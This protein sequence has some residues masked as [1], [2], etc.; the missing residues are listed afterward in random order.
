VGPTDL[1]RSH[2][3]SPLVHS[4]GVGANLQDHLQIRSVYRLNDGAVTLNHWLR[5]AG[6]LIGQA[7][8]GFQYVFIRRGPLAMAPSQFGVFARSNVKGDGTATR[9]ATRAGSVLESPAASSPS[10]SSEGNRHHRDPHPSPYERDTP[11]LQFHLQPLSLDDLGDPSMKLH[12]FPGLTTSVCNLRPSSRGSVELTGPSSFHNPPNIDPNY[13]ATKRDRTVAAAA[14]RLARTLVLGR[15]STGRGGKEQP[16]PEFVGGGDLSSS[17]V[18][19]ASPSLPVAPLAS[20]FAC[21]YGPIV[22]HFPG[23]QIESEE[24]LAREAGNISTSIFHPVGTCAMGP[25]GGARRRRGR[26]VGNDDDGGSLPLPVVDE[27]CRVFGVSQLRVCDASVMPTITS[28][29]TNSPT[30]AIAEKASEM[31]LHDNKY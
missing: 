12:P 31:I 14:L 8:L 30:M 10:S 24:E 7:L 18:S 25:H 27:R 13:L 1:L 20:S 6:S 3:V 9:A 22:E 23:E 11:D 28:G 4:P 15:R 2:G 16:Q 19:G 17:S 26:S 21:L 29:N 5:G